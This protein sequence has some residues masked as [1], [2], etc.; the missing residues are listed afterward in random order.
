MSRIVTDWLLKTETEGK[1]G[2]LF[3]I[4]LRRGYQECGSLF[5]EVLQGKRAGGSGCASVLMPENYI[6]LFKTPSEE[7]A[8]ALIERAEPKITDIARMIREG[9]ILPEQQVTERI[10][11]AAGW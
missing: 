11:S 10:K 6:A 2:H 8:L 9:R 5:T 1:P 4:D 7:E 3:C